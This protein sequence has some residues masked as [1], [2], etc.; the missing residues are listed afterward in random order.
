M[1]VRCCQSYEEV[2]EGDFGEVIRLD[3]DGLQDLN[4][5]TAWVN[6]GGTYWVSCEWVCFKLI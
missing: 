1:S 6:R 4:V 3:R 2:E 5:Q